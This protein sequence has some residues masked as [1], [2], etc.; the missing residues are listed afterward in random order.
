ML[1]WQVERLSRLSTINWR[2]SSGN[3][4]IVDMPVVGDDVGFRFIVGT[5]QLRQ[6]AEM[7]VEL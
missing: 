7:K 2:I 4:E 3:V 6:I 5:P 1:S